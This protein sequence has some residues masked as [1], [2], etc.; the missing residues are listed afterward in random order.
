MSFR[1]SRSFAVA[2]VT[3]ATFT[4]L[5]AYSIAVPVLPDLSAR[6]GASPTTIGLMFSAFGVTLVAVSIPM[7]AVSD[8]V[9]RKL[10]L[11]LGL[12]ALALST[13]LFA[14]ADRLS[15]L[16]AA[17][18]V[19]GAADAVTWVVGFAL[20]ADLYGPA[21]RGRVM[22]L[23][24]SG[25]NFGLMIGPSLG[26]WLY[27][28]GGVRLPFL[29]VASLAAAVAVGFLWLRLPV[30]HA[31][32]EAVPLRLVLGV[33]AIASCAIAVIIAAGTVSMLEPVVSL[34]LA[35]SL[36]L[37]PARIGLVF[38][39][40]AVA[41]TALHPIYGRLADRWGG[42]RLT[43]IG[44]VAMASMLPIL[45][46]AW[47]FESAVALYVLQGAAIALMV[48]PSLAYMAE[49]MSD[50]GVESFGVAYGLYNFAWGIGLLAGPAIGGFA[51]EKLGF[52]R[53]ALL[54]M[55]AVIAATWLLARSGPRPVRAHA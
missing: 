31:A 19:Q 30:S 40:A 44:L 41:A 38:G 24:M 1:S 29:T 36:Q 26:G 25:T 15:W 8:R 49:A 46:Q 47:S 10:P 32:R 35:S 22:G 23:V 45:T 2:L 16:F 54:W 17:R 13:L 53:L 7:G 52:E 39:I 42:R 34:W 4:D 43:I 21:E 27:E 5:V 6:L 3:F 50:A 12:I 11:V 55:P 51:Y 33:P 14:F 48:T 28:T 37:N 9:G 20:I 18:L